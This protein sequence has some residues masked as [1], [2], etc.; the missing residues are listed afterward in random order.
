ML[1]K[2]GFLIK[3]LWQYLQMTCHGTNDN[4]IRL[5]GSKFAH[6]VD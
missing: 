1:K 2:A 4:S 5:K 3:D 6:F